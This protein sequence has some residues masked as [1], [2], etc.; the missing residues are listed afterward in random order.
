MPFDAKATAREEKE[1]G[2]EG[3]K[4]RRSRGKREKNRQRVVVE[5][6]P[7]DS[8]AAMDDSGDRKRLGF[9]RVSK[10]TGNAERLRKTTPVR[11]HLVKT[12]AQYNR[13]AFRIS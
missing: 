12:A 4:R 3:E 9:R 10:K 7:A 11:R 5:Q 2:K 1:E 8:E 13:P 6:G